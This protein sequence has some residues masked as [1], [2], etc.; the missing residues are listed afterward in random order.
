VQNSKLPSYHTL[1]CPVAKQ[2]QELGTSTGTPLNMAAPA[3]ETAGPDACGC[4]SQIRRVSTHDSETTITSVTHSHDNVLLEVL[5]TQSDSQEAQNQVPTD[6]LGCT[7]LTPVCE[8]LHTLLVCQARV[9]GGLLLCNTV[10]CFFR[11]PV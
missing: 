1:L 10:Q 9:M 4:A 8:L 6:Q 11:Q 2:P 7:S 3:P 5:G